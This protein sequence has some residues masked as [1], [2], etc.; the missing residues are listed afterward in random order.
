MARAK[1]AEAKES[2]KEFQ[3]DGKEFRYSGRIYPENKKETKKCD[4]TPMNITLNGLITIKGCKLFQSDKNSWIQFPQYQSG[5]D[6]KDYIYCP[7]ELNEELDALVE[8]I[9]KV[10]DA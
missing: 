8:E 9:E 10:L 1:K 3:F 6:Y 4:I 5:E 2:F 7:K